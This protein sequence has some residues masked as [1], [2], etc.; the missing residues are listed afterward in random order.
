MKTSAIRKIRTLIRNARAMSGNDSLKTSGSKNACLTSGQPEAL[1]TTR[2]TIPTT[3]S[4]EIVATAIARPPP[5]DAEP[6]MREPLLPVSALP[7]VRRA[8]AGEVRP[9]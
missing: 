1:T 9:L 7:Q 6:M 8:G 4:V 5:G 3:T 2:T